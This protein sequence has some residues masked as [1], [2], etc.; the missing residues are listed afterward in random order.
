MGFPLDIPPVYTKA[1]ESRQA[2]FASLQ[3]SV[4]DVLNN[5]GNINPPGSSVAATSEVAACGIMSRKFL[6]WVLRSGRAQHVIDLIRIDRES[7][8][9]GNVR[10]EVTDTAN[11]AVGASELAAASKAVGDGA[12]IREGG[13]KQSRGDMKV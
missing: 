7:V 12:W 13:E 6:E 10:N 2:R 5:P 11:S 9:Y 4:I 3:Q 1:L 8:S